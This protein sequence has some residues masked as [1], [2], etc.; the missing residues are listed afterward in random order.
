DT[1]TWRQSVRAARARNDRP[2]LERLAREVDVRD[3]PAEELF[4][5]GMSLNQRGARESALA[6]LRRGQQAFPGDFW[7]N[8]NLG[9]ALYHC[10]PRRLEG[11][12]RYLTAALALKPDSPPRTSTWA[13]LSGCTA[14]TRRRSPPSKRPPP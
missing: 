6:Q 14:G 7:M 11:A 4:L 3:Q 2:A 10:R 9:W 5:L 12:I 1:D 13:A 8:H